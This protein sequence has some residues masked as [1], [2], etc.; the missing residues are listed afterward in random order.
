M[1]GCGGH[2]LPDCGIKSPSRAPL[3]L[4]CTTSSPPASTPITP[5]TKT[6]THT[7]TTPCR[8]ILPIL[9]SFPYTS[10]EP[11]SSC[12]LRCWLRLLPLP[13][14]DQADQRLPATSPP[15][16]KVTADAPTAGS[17]RH[18]PRDTPPKRQTRTPGSWL[19]LAAW[20]DTSLTADARARSSCRPLAF[21]P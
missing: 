5:Q 18:T 21:S 13:A 2:T 3:L 20:R 11:A 4:F 7:P 15:A 10:K 19:C 14:G 12:S 17:R 1:F 6:H 9:R 8:P 16:S